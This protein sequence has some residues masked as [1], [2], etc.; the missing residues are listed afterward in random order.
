MVKKLEEYKVSE[1]EVNIRVTLCK[2]YLVLSA[3]YNEIVKLK[4]EIENESMW[5]NVII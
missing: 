1:N 3:T 4:K 5:L 2:I